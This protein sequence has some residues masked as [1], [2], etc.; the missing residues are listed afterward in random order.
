MQDV[1][2]EKYPFDLD[3]FK[4]LYLRWFLFCA[5]SVE[6]TKKLTENKRG[7]EERGEEKPRGKSESNLST[8]IMLLF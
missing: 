3:Y 2:L 8:L 6:S 5:S 1:V 7:E 4:F